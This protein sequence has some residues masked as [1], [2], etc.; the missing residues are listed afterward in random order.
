MAEVPISCT[1]FHSEILRK[2]GGTSQAVD[3][4]SKDWVL[5][6][7]MNTAEATGLKSSGA[8]WL[9]GVLDSMFLPQALQGSRPSDKAGLGRKAEAWVLTTTEWARENCWEAKQQSWI[10]TTVG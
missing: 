10:L 6:G 7:N 9:K 8:R 3:L 5:E 4:S 2:R 1:I